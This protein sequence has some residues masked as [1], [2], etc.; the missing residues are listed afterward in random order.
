MQS[1]LITYYSQS[2]SLTTDNNNHLPFLSSSIHLLFSPQQRARKISLLASLRVSNSG[3][4][5]SKAAVAVTQ[6]A[7]QSIPPH[8]QTAKQAAS[9]LSQAKP[10][11]WAN[12]TGRKGLLR[13]RCLLSRLSA[14]PSSAHTC[15]HALRAL[16]VLACLSATRITAGCRLS[17]AL[18]ST[19]TRS[20]SACLSHTV[21][22]HWVS[23]RALHCASVCTAIAQAHRNPDFV[24]PAEPIV[25]LAA[26]PG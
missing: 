16:R 14:P 12:F 18:I 26:A 3:R 1:P 25:D 9:R 15:A 19:R 13:Q 7:S 6:A 8:T 24:C 22:G 21:Q 5:R 2:D 20:R 4:S 17:V 23:W 11:N 10:K